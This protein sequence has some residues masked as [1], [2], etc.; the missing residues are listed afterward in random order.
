MP[1]YIDA[2]ELLVRLREYRK[3]IMDDFKGV[4]EKS[5][6][7][8]KIADMSMTAFY[9]K[10]HDLFKDLV[11]ASTYEGRIEVIDHMITYI[12]ETIGNP[13][14]GDYRARSF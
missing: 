1:R 3:L 5:S 14:N 11:E 7:D 8:M 12:E 6:C 9:E 2:D 10:S 13:E 4:S